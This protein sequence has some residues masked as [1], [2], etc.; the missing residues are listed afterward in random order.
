MNRYLST[1]A[2][3]LGAAVVLWV[4]AGYLGKHT[5]TA[6]LRGNEVGVL[7]PEIDDGDSIVNRT[8]HARLASR[9]ILH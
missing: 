1:A 7:P 3:V 9:A 6:D 5:L 4:G 8:G 2:F